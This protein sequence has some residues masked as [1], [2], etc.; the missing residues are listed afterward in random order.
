[1]YP[2]KPLSSLLRKIYRLSPSLSRVENKNTLTLKI[3]YFVP[4]TLFIIPTK[5]LIAKKRHL[6][7]LKD[8]SF[9][10]DKK[11]FDQ[12]LSSINDHY[13]V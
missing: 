7:L 2:I 3:F 4:S 13:M 1:M 5:Y 12:I 10:A 6:R 9:T 11:K 8:V